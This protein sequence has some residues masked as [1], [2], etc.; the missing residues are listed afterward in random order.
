MI[1]VYVTFPSVELA[2]K[3]IKHLL[4]KK[5][6]A[7]GMAYSGESAYEWKEK[8]VQ[9]KEAVAF[10][11]TRKEV[12]KKLEQDIA[13]HHPYETP[14]ILKISVKANKPFGKWVNASVPKKR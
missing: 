9:T 14:C 5:L 6:I 3:T 2:K 8:I 7:C 10:L 12:W 4:E 11:K 1:L 13:R